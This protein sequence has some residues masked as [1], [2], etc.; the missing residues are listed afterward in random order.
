VLLTRPHFSINPGDGG[1]WLADALAR[2]YAAGARHLFPSFLVP[3]PA[4]WIVPA[5]LVAAAAA[6]ALLARRTAVGRTLGRVAV[7]VWLVVSALVITAV[8]QRLDGVV[9]VE[10]PQVERLGGVTEPP[11]G[12]FSRFLQPNGWRIADG[13]GVVVP[14]NLAA[15]DAVT[16]EGWLD[17]AAQ[18][19]AGLLV[20]WDDGRSTEIAI[21]G[22]VRGSSPLPS[23]PAAGRRR[24]HLSLRSPAGGSVV[25]D[26]VVVR[27]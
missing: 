25:L 26:R 5:A 27:R 16:L 19:G 10:E 3:S 4:T 6:L 2:R 9:E 14:L 20:R 12:T 17:G 7:A 11:E 24:L 1:W 22:S 8:T 18:R 23:P 15:G 21:S 13:D